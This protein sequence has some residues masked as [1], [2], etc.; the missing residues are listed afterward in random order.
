MFESKLLGKESKFRTEHVGRIVADRTFDISKA[1]KELGFK[2]KV[3]FAEGVKRMRKEFGS[4][5]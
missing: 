5:A 2:P 1:K 4:I 3:T